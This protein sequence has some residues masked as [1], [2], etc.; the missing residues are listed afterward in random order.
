MNK[1]FT[2][3]EL[4]QDYQIREFYYNVDQ[5]LYKWHQDKENRL[6]EV[7]N[8][9]KNWQFQI[10]N[11]LPVL[12][13][14]GDKIYINERKWHRLI[15]GE[16]NLKIKVYFLD[17]SSSSELSSSSSDLSDFLPLS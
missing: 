10:D 8:Y 15:P 11:E 6:I 1:P 3:L 4:T 13:N 2:I 17:S 5:F 12:L 16:N 7:L 14:N 9:P